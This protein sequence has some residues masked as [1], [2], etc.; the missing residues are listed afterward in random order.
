[1]RESLVVLLNGLAILIFLSLITSSPSDPSFFNASGSNE[2][3]NFMGAFGAN[4]SAILLWTFGVVSYLF[5]PLLAY[6]SFKLYQFE[7]YQLNLSRLEK[8]LIYFG[9][10]L[11]ISSSCSLVSLF[12][13]ILDSPVGAGGVIGIEFYVLAEEAFGSSGAIVTLIIIFLLSLSLSLHVSWVEIMDIT[14][15]AVIAAF[16]KLK[17]LCKFFYVGISK[18]RIQIPQKEKT[19][20]TP[21]D[22][23]KKKMEIIKT[24]PKAWIEPKV[25]NIEAS[26][27]I[28]VEKQ[29]EMFTIKD[30][31]SLPGLDLLKDGEVN[32]SGFSDEALQAMS[33]LLEIKLSDFNITAQVVSVTPGP[34]VTRFEIQPAPGI[35]V[36]QISNLSKDL[37]RA[38]ST[39]SVRVVE[40]IPGRPFIGIEIP[41]EYRELVTLGEIIKS[42]SYEEL[43]SSLTLAL[44]K[45]ISGNPVVADLV[46]MPHLLI[47]GT[48]G[49]GKS[50]AINT[51]ILSFLYKSTPSN[52]RLILIDPK[53]L[54]LSVYEG[55]PHLLTPV[56]TNMKEAA[57]ALKWCVAEMDRR[58]HLMSHLGVRNLAGYN[59]KVEESLKQKTPIPDPMF[60][61]TESLTEEI[62]YLEV[63]PNIVIVID[64]LADMMMVVGR[65]V[66]ELITRL[67][68]KARASGIHMIVA[69]QRPSV[70]VITGLIKANIPSR[71]AFQVSA[72]VDSRTILDQM[73]A[74]SL[75]GDGDMLFLPSGASVPVRVHGAFVS[76]Q[77][78]HS[79]V[80]DLKKVGKPNFIE[81]VII[82]TIAPNSVGGDADSAEDDPLY[83][84][85]V[86]VVVESRRASISYVQRRLKIGYNRAARMI[87]TMEANGVVAKAEGSNSLEVIAP[88]PPE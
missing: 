1:V 6:F 79:V 16:K 68:Q 4:L 10:V 21:R 81:E 19:K 9:I 51:M 65:T 25:T 47:A 41:N 85:A 86:S 52:V 38:L 53:M 28:E 54:E 40:V 31:G 32:S 83:G 11:F 55:I 22:L 48:T 8:F 59:K 56:V 7:K 29:K 69:T 82:E 63:L 12:P 44:G 78:V 49:S 5:I 26:Q 33:K 14:G 45:D 72:K 80:R 57:N 61:R 64:E 74:E 37:A 30:G 66:E 34:V 70:D 23:H 58:Y 42:K 87:E 77:E 18:I 20:E 13:S 46:K 84:Q 67:A 75:L 35:K 3:S 36:S 2:F 62:R 43:S 27:R 76:D 71:I 60:K 73:G 39:I 88:P 17:Q 15:G 24:R 50:V